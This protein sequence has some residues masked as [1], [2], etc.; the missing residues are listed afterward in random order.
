MAVVND[1]CHH[2][3]SAVDQFFKQ[4]ETTVKLGALELLARQ[5]DLIWIGAS[6]AFVYFLYQALTQDTP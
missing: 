3:F 1:Y 4:T 6:L 5:F 2:E